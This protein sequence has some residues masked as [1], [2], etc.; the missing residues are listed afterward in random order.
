M[1]NYQINQTIAKTDL[2]KLYNSVGWFA[3]TKT[4]VNLMAA[5]TNSLMVV[6]AWADNQLV[7]LVRVVGDGQTIIFIQDILVDPKFQN[8]H[9]GTEL[10]NRVLSQYSAV[11]QKVLLTEEAPDVRHFYEKFGFKSADQGT[12]VA[13][14]KNF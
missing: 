7:G 6:S 4:R 5:V 12:L 14:Y 3:Y 10:M 2:I 9:T 1:I 11:R 8:Q 13:F